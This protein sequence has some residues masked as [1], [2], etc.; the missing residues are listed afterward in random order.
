VTGEEEPRIDQAI[1]KTEGFFRSLGVGTRL[2][3]YRIPAESALLVAE[4]L[5]DRKMLL[6]EQQDIGRRQVE[7]ILSLRA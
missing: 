2:S 4:R 7:Q 3:D 1:T 5:A 6:G